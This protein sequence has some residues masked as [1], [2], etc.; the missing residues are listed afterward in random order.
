[1]LTTTV[2]NLKSSLN[3]GAPKRMTACLSYVDWGD[4]IGILALLCHWR[5]LSIGKLVNE[6]MPKGP[7]TSSSIRLKAFHEWAFFET[8][9]TG[10]SWTPMGEKMQDKIWSKKFCHNCQ[11][12]YNID[13]PMHTEGLNM[14]AYKIKYFLFCK[15]LVLWGVYD[16]FQSLWSEITNNS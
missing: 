7:M 15:I 9:A 14:L 16:V 10:V 2:P 4:V 12:P 11:I 3:R 6:L 13:R 1:M 8:R 5:P